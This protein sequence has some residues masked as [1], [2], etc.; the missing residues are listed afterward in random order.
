VCV[1]GKTDRDQLLEV[2][3]SKKKIAITGTTI[4]SHLIGRKPHKGTNILFSPREWDYD[5]EENGII[6]DWLKVI[7]RKN[8]WNLMVKINDIHDKDKYKGYAVFSHRDQLDHLEV[9]AKVLSEADL[10]ITMAEYTFELLAQYLDIP[11]V[12]A[13]IV[14]PRPFRGDRR[15]ID[16][17]FPRSNAIKRFSDIN[18]M[19]SVIKHQ[20]EHPEE[21]KEERKQIVIDEGGAD[22]E[23]P[24]EEMIKVIK[25]VK[26]R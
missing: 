26:R 13:D 17:H 21:L 9:C 4:F 18:E 6:M 10:L 15:Y 25:N 7:C 20:L 1:W 16:Y 11:V 3:I 2:G 5:I 14:M 24:L 8:G 12:I 23:N 19:E 22:I